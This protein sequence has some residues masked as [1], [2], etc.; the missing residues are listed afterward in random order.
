MD[1]D[2]VVASECARRGIGVGCMFEDTRRGR[3]AS[4]LPSE[5]DSNR[6]TNTGIVFGLN[7]GMHMPSKAPWV[8][9]TVVG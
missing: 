8:A 7:T 1:L 6:Y 2:R 5:L 4:Y 9:D 3:A